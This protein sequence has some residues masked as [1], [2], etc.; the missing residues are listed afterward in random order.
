[1]LYDSSETIQIWHKDQSRNE[2][3]WFKKNA[4]FECNFALYFL[5]CIDIEMHWIKR[6]IVSSWSIC[7]SR[8]RNRYAFITSE[9]KKQRRSFKKM[10]RMI[11]IRFIT[12][13]Y[14]LL[15]LWLQQLL[16]TLSLR[17]QWLR[18][19]LS[20]SFLSLILFKRF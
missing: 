8:I 7:S 16:T 5:N 18:K 20:E 19:L 2:C 1:M 9:G 14:T 15:I 17:S 6:R 3:L 4:K 12:I 11:Q 13:L 10:L